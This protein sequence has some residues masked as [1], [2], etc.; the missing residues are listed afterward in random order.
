MTHPFFHRPFTRAVKAGGDATW[1]VTR[2][3]VRSSLVVPRLAA[4]ALGRRLMPE[5]PYDRVPAGRTVRLRGRGSTFVVDVPGP[6]PDA[7][8]VVLLHGLACTAYLNWFPVLG[9]L[10]DRYR[11]VAFDQRWHGR[12][13]AS[14]RFRIEDCADD[15]VAVLDALGID[16]ALFAGYSLGG[17]VA[18]ETWHRHPDRVAGLVLASTARNGQGRL[19]ERLFFPVLAATMNPVS[20]HAAARVEQLAQSLPLTPDV[21]L[22]D[23]TSWGLAQVRSTSGWAYPEVVNAVGHFDSAPWIGGVDVPTAVV[24][25]ERDRAIPTRRQHRLAAAVPGARVF[26][27]PGGHASVV[28][29]AARWLPVFEKA[30]EDVWRRAGRDVA[31]TTDRRGDVSAG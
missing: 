5:P 30:L 15:A 22:T 14:E 7:P 28:L 9:A 6:T 12:G 31:L 16:R 3:A 1:A 2:L 8:V 17:F 20:R 13:I 27:A 4:D 11:V 24:V 10:A 21:E 25:T 26:S 18:Q 19:Q 23:L 29:D